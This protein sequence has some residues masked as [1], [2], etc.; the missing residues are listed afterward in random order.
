MILYF[1]LSLSFKSHYKSK[2]KAISLVRYFILMLKI[3]LILNI[4]FSSIIFEEFFKRSIL[5]QPLAS[6]STIK[7]SKKEIR[8]SFTFSVNNFGITISL[9]LQNC[10]LII[11]SAT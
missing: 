6:A 10:P 7:F 1:H 2:Y 11:Y 4:L 9:L 5:F 3:I 8:S